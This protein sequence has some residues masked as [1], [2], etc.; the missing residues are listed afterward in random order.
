M[1]NPRKLLASRALRS[2]FFGTRSV[3]FFSPNFGARFVPF[4]ENLDWNSFRSSS[5][6]VPLFEAFA[7]NRSIKIAHFS[8]NLMLFQ[9]KQAFWKFLRQIRRKNSEHSKSHGFPLSMIAFG[10]LLTAMVIEI[11][12]IFGTKFFPKNVVPFRSVLAN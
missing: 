12:K 8:E 11:K 5:V 7:P 2:D 4:H 6:P 3:P 9:Q 10:L 1:I